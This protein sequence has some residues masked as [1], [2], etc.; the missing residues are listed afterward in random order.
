MNE[1]EVWEEAK[2][3]FFEGDKTG[4]L[5]IHGFTG[6]NQSMRPLG[7]ALA[8][9]GFTV[10]GPRLPGHGTSVEDLSKRKHTEWIFEV[11]RALKELM[12]RC[13]K[14]FITGLSMGGTLTLLLGEMYGESIDGLIPINAALF[15]N[16]PLLP[17]VPVAK[18]LLK[19]VPGV[20]SDIKDPQQ[21]ELCYEK[22]PV[23]AVHE[24]VKLMKLTRK[25][26]SKITQPILVFVSRNDHVVPP[27]KASY[28]LDSVSS[29]EKE[30]VWLENSYHVATLDYDRE[31]IF[32]RC[33]QFIQDHL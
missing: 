12:K 13:E 4:V 19:T 25:G 14:I 15:L 10:L 31:T 11:E 7:E 24:L 5:V 17:L 33:A 32:S 9:K 3:Y 29:T 6:C 23:P 1:Q 8:S 2:P 27:G 18:Y 16:N 22:V 28:I 26:L 20:G 30:L 21:K